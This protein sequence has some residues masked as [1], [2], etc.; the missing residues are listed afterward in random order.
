MGNTRDF[1]TSLM[2]TRKH[3][4]DNFFVFNEKER[5]IKEQGLVA[6]IFNEDF[7]NITLSYLIVH[8]HN[9]FRDQAHI[10]GVPMMRPRLANA[11]GLWLTNHHAVK[12]VLE[13]I[14]PNTAQGHDLIPPRA[15]KASSQKEF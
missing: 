2:H 4:P 7:R 13:N 10:N 8:R 9:A 15:V 12:V 5:V 11:F 6:E 14:K 3:V 1:W